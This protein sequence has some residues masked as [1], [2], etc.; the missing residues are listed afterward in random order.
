MEDC[1]DGRGSLLQERRHSLK[2]KMNPSLYKEPTVGPL[3]IY[4]M[5]LNY[6]QNYHKWEY[7]AADPQK[8]SKV[9][10]M[11]GESGSGKTT[12][13]NAII[14]Y[15]FGVEWK[16]DY[17]LELIIEKSQRSKVNIY[18]INHAEDFRIQDS[19]TI[20]D[21]NG[22]GDTADKKI[23]QL[24]REFFS[25]SDLNHVDALCFVNPSPA[26]H[27][28]PTQHMFDSV[29][30][31]F[32]QSIRENITFFNTFT[33]GQDTPD[34]AAMTGALCMKGYKHFTFN[35][36]VLHA[37]N[38]PSEGNKDECAAHERQ[39]V[40]GME[41][42]ESFLKHVSNLSR[43]TVTLNTD[44]LM[45]SNALEV[46]LEGQIL[47]IEEAMSKLHELE[48]TAT[49]LKRHR[50]DIEENE[51]FEFQVQKIVKK[52]Q[53]TRETSTNCGACLSTCH[54]DCLVFSKKFI[55]FCE[56]F[57]WNA[58]CKVCGHG[59]D[60]HSSE[61]LL[62]QI[63]MEST[64]ITYSSV[65]ERYKK[66]NKEMTYARVLE[67]LKTETE[68]VEEEAL[69]LIRSATGSYQ[70]LEGKSTRSVE[71][72]IN[73]LIATERHERKSGFKER[74]EMLNKARLKLKVCNT[75]GVEERFAHSK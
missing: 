6:V 53:P 22:Y 12:L 56:V 42:I 44:V 3:T 18:Q 9:V 5:E 61:N 16:Y 72:F 38:C 40:M 24:I 48:Q 63:T 36:S 51:H 2:V 70:L 57:H 74:I 14:N 8:S 54:R 17:R 69:R 7:G 29:L 52:K 62:W 19:L 58:T 60:L 35:T 25:S 26:A 73:L 11:I 31:I 65:R 21:T 23:I 32:G 41:S 46:T 33:D 66:D 68:K 10:M 64:R 27:V 43:K 59:K 20:I 45:S 1:T 39:W 37:N 55:Y 71:D 13:I 49:L 30:S 75:S 34:P 50:V 4:R 15:I 67:E 47:K 28:I